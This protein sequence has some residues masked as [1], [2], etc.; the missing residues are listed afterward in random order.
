MI[1]LLLLSRSRITSF[2]SILRG[3]QTARGGAEPGSPSAARRKQEGSWD[4]MKFGTGG[5]LGTPRPAVG[6]GFACL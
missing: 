3:E 2:G 1:P 5:T 6:A 4:G